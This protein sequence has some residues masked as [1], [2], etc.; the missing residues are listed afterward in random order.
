VSPARRETTTLLRFTMLSQTVYRHHAGARSVPSHLEDARLD[1]LGQ[2]LGGL[3][4]VPP[5]SFRLIPGGAPS[6][7]ERAASPR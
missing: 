4:P 1:V 5:A 6:G 7:M 3:P 2:A